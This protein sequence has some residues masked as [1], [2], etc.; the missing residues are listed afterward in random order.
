VEFLP[1]LAILLFF[2]LLVMRPASRRA[3]EARALQASLKVGDKIMLTSG[4]FGTLVELRDDRVLISIASG[5][6]I[7]VVRPAIASVERDEVTQEPE[8]PTHTEDD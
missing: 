5:T 6:E 3:K 2:W 7:E 1:L 8:L 4:I